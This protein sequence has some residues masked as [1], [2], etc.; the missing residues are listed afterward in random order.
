MVLK[1]AS[2]LRCLVKEAEHGVGYMD[3]SCSCA[4]AYRQ[5]IAVDRCNH[6]WNR[7]WLKLVVK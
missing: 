6:I 4:F 1:R 2:G 3:S 5:T 7:T